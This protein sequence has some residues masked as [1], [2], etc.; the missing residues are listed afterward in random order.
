MSIEED[1][2]IPY[3]K[4]SDLVYLGA[5]AQGIVFGGQY[6]GELV[7]V[8]QLRD[9]NDC[10]IKHLRKLNHENIGKSIFFIK[11]PSETSTW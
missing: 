2:D 9:K 7:A 3:E 11:G 8:K 1:W 5:G 4:L 10:N 6:R